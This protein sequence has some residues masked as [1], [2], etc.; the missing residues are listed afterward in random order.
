M[1]AKNR[2]HNAVRHALESD[3]WNTTDN[4]L[5]LRVGTRDLYVNLG[6][7]RLLA[8]ERGSE[9]I[10]VEIKT[11]GGAAVF[12]DALS[13]GV[14]VQGLERPICNSWAS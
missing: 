8:A 9:K 2:Y 7:E 12:C 14:K 1:P 4:P 6:A 10:A 5:P 3:G 13:Q 11:F